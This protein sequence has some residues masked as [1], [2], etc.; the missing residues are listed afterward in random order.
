MRVKFVL[1]ASV[2]AAVI[3]AGACVLIIVAALGSWRYALAPA[4]Y[5]HSRLVFLAAFVPPW[6]SAISAGVF[7]YRHT[8]HRRKLQA[9]ITICVAAAIATLLIRLLTLYYS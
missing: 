3:G 9:L 2:V 7:V 6:V 4:S 8:A 1:L 5:Q